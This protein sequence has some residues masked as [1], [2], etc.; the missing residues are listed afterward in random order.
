MD[1][2]CQCTKEVIGALRDNVT[3]GGSH[4]NTSSE[5]CIEVHDVMNV[6]I[7]AYEDLTCAENVVNLS[8]DKEILEL[9]RQLRLASGNVKISKNKYKLERKWTREE[10]KLCSFETRQ[11]DNILDE[12][13]SPKSIVVY[14]LLNCV[15]EK[16]SWGKRVISFRNPTHFLSTTD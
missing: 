10:M 1:R 16:P 11:N 5:I 4:T 6:V 3:C 7:W 8:R 9:I 15:S 2:G 12:L 14:R 13:T